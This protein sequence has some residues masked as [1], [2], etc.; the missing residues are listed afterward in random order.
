MTH[1]QLKAKIDKIDNLTRQIDKYAERIIY[2]GIAILVVLAISRMLTPTATK[3][4]DDAWGYLPPTGFQT[5]DGGVVAVAISD[6]GLAGLGIFRPHSRSFSPESAALSL[7][8]HFKL[9]VD[10]VLPEQTKHRVWPVAGGSLETEVK[11]AVRVN[12]DHDWRLLGTMAQ[13]RSTNEFFF[14]L[15]TDL[16]NESNLPGFW[17]GDDALKAMTIIWLRAEREEEARHRCVG[18]FDIE[19]SRTDKQWYE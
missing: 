5:S 14:A 8:N 16:A 12:R 19:R 9:T 1:E 6:S 18:G 2:G 3:Q 13:N 17:V 7:A 15:A 4:A 10:S 11:Q